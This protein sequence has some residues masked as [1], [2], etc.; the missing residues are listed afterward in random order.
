MPDIKLLLKELS[1][2]TMTQQVTLKHDEARLQY[3]PQTNVCASYAEFVAVI[4]DYYNHHYSHCISRGARLP[5]AEAA[6]RAKTLL[7]GIYQQHGGTIGTAFQDAKDGRNGGLRG[8]LDAMAETLKM[9]A[10][11]QYMREVLDRHAE[12][13]NWAQKVELVRQ[14][15]KLC[16][17]QIDP[18][19]QANEPER[20]A[21][22]Y[23]RLIATYI[24][25]M[26]KA[27]STFRRY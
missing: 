26:R 17:A 7:D 5:P 19:I 18:T 14:L 16:G 4:A 11:Q 22:D 13:D 21:H 27:A 24:E 1:E 10:M 8:I 3:R 9:E 6:A 2:S 25:L 20:Y 23:A 15:L 12:P